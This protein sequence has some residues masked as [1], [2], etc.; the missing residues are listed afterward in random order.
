[1]KGESEDDNLVAVQPEVACLA[2]LISSP[3]GLPMTVD[4]MEQMEEG[5]SSSRGTVRG[6]A[7]VAGRMALDPGLLGLAGSRGCRGEHWVMGADGS[8]TVVGVRVGPVS[9][10]GRRAAIP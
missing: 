2:G 9:G 10:G 8:A 5:G 1:M 7:L 3:T 6:T 4:D